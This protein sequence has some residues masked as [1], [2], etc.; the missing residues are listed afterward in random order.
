MKKLKTRLQFSGRENVNRIMA[1]PTK[2]DPITYFITQ[3]RIIR[4]GFYMMNSYSLIGDWAV[5]VLA[6]ITVTL[7]AFAA[8]FIIGK[9]ITPI[10]FAMLT[11]GIGLFSFYLLNRISFIRTFGRAKSSN[12]NIIRESF[13]WFTATLTNF[14]HGIMISL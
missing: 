4:I 14:N 5:T 9:S 1:W 6:Y 2:N 13:I 10:L 12:I 7:Y 8:P 11:S 3:F